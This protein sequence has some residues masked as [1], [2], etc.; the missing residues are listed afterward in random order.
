[1]S[2]NKA[3]V[4]ARGLGSRMRKQSDVALTPEQELAAASGAK[5][6]MP[7]G[8][9]PF[10]DHVLTKLADAGLTNVCLVIGPEHTAVRDYYDSVER[11]R[12]TIDYAV[13][14]EP[15]GT[16]DAVAAAQ[17]FAGSDRFVVVNGD[18]LYPTESLTILAAEPGMATVGFVPED[19][20]ANS[21]I[22]AERM[23]A[24]ALLTPDGS[25]GLADIIEKPSPEVAATLGPDRLVSMNCW[26][27][28]PEVF[29]ACASIAPS[30]RGELEIV[31]AVRWLIEH[32][33]RFTVVPSSEGVWDLSSRADVGSVADALGGD[34]VRL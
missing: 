12:I 1:M 11:E 19:L 32:G 2:V 31:D 33:T 13:Q 27:F 23:P 25:G 21:N 28:G 4:M 22:P 8:G 17:E 6:M 26:L 30:S 5:A 34:E 3:V 9:R 29:T 14:Q 20:V 24:L 7:L 10:L 18:N 16:A 15:R